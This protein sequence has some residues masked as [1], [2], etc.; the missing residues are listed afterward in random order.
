VN[1]LTF[2]IED[3]FHILDNDS[4]RGEKQW[5]NFAPRL[6]RNTDR[7]L[8]LL[9]ATGVRATFFCL[10]WV[11]EKH[12]GVIKRIHAAGYELGSHSY[13]HQ[14]VY[15]QS[16][17]EFVHDLEGSLGRL[18]DLT[19]TK[20]LAYRAPGFSITRSNTWAF[21]VLAAHGIEID[22]SVFPASRAHGGFPGFGTAQPAIVDHAGMK[23]KEFPI[24]TVGLAGQQLIFSGGG[25]FRLLPYPAIRR[26]MAT[27]PYVMTYFHPRDF[28]PDQ[29]VLPGLKWHR[30]FKSYY[31]L[32]SAFDKLKRLLQEFPFVDLRT[33]E[34]A[35]DWRNQ[36]VVKV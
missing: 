3:W 27:S 7:L 15:E 14:L 13:R 30:V 33:A 19:G 36:P 12:P 1:I 24:N 26:L 5:A 4:S 29:P 23:L 2:D 9:A 18:E 32:R 34:K 25:Y 21:E 10:G 17:E 20:V 11:A 6:E 31:G 8:D 16:R 28:D 35:I 22:S